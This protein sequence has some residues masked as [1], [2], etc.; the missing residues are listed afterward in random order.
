MADIEVVGQ[1]QTQ[2][3]SSTTT[4]RP[5][6]STGSANPQAAST[7][8]AAPAQKA[9]DDRQRGILAD[10]QKERRARQTYE[11]QL[12]SMRTELEAERR[13]VQAL[14][15][16]NPRSAEETE[17]DAVRQRFGQ[18]FPGLAKLSDEKIERLLAVAERADSLE[19]ATSH[20]WQTHGRQM[21]SSVTDAVAKELG[22]TLSDRQLTRIKREYVAAAEG[23]PEFLARHEAGDP[24]LVQE[25]VKE[26]MEDFFEPARRKITATELSR[27]RS[28]PS[29]R[30][31]SVPGPGGKKLDYN[32]PKAVEDALVASFREHG[33]AFG[34]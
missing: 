28:V 9:E 24:T 25:F 8:G 23:D 1:D 31:R 27:Q 34:E 19:E 29:A 13:R 3:T 12:N 16:V 20:H 22:G 5:D 7:Q 4:E 33:G 6:G 10:L 2:D 30:D 32:N 14:A 11:T 18:V 15:G 26:M 17:V 21:L